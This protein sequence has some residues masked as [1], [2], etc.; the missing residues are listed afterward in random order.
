MQTVTAEDAI[1]LQ[2]ELIEIKNELTH[3]CT[4]LQVKTST[5]ILTQ[6]LLLIS[7][8]SFLLMMLLITINTV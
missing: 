2:Q 3:L 1:A 6:L 7:T 5:L 4:L 8:A